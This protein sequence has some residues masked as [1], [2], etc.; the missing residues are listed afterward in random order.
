M[1]SEERT[2]WRMMEAVAYFGALLWVL[3]LIS[4]DTYWDVWRD[5]REARTRLCR[6]VLLR[7]KK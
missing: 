1:R 7:R 3:R 6:A 4:Q 2:H 5:N